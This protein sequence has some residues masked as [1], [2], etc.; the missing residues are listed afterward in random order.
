MISLK[1]N[2]SMD[3]GIS[4]GDGHMRVHVDW[5]LDAIVLG[6]SVR[7]PMAELGM[8]GELWVEPFPSP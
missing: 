1:S 2:A 3:A 8:K 4:H 5:A 7:I 6:A